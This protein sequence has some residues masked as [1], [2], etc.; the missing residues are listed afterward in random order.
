MLG[1]DGTARSADVEH[2]FFFVT[3]ASATFL[4]R[5]PKPATSAQVFLQNERACNGDGLT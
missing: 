5:P 1:A 3:Y 2:T 4:F